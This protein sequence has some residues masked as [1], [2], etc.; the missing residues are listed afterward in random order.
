MAGNSQRPGARRKSG[1]KKGATAG[2]G[3]QRRKGLTGKGPTPAAVDRVGH[4]AARQARRRPSAEGSRRR[5]LDPGADLVLGRNPA[6]EA[7]RAAVPARTLYVQRNI[8]VDDRVREVIS[9]AERVGLTVREASRAELDAMSAGIVH[10]GLVLAVEPFAYTPLE[11]MLATP[12]PL[13]V[14]LDGVTDPH[15]L[16]AISR[17]AAA[18]GATAVIIPKRRAAPVTAAAWRTSA[19]ALATLPVCQVGNLT[20]TLQQ[21]ADSGSFSVGLAADAEDRLTDLDA[22]FVHG[23]LALVIGGEGA[24]LSRLVAERV[25]RRVAID[26]VGTTE[27]LNASVAA[28][29]ALHW[30]AHLRA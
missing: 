22:A 17:S 26:M 6:L 1:T 23:G 5:I 29:V 10:Q 12:D 25:D 18:F 16:G 13:W 9:S 7:I 19:G 2:S 4:P 24:G 21:L 27:S 14:V 11:S 15:N 8:D 3:G 28:G 30:I 20:R